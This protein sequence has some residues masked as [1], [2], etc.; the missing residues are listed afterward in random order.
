M[1]GEHRKSTKT[2]VA[3]DLAQ[4]A[5]VKTPFVPCE[6]RVGGR[7]RLKD[8]G[9]R[10]TA[11]GGNPFLLILQPSAQG[12]R[13]E[14]RQRTDDGGLR[15]RSEITSRFG[16]SGFPGATGSASARPSMGTLA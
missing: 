10:V 3:L 8:E 12:P 14:S 5:P 16:F 2:Q 9:G 1:S 7:G 13:Y 11:E 15:N 4:G 6:V